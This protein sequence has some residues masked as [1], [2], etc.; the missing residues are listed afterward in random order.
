M[1]SLFVPRADP[2]C[3]SP[4]AEFLNSCLSALPCFVIQ[5]RSET[6]K[7]KQM[8]IDIERERERGRGMEREKD[9]SQE[10]DQGR[11]RYAWRCRF[12]DPHDQ[13]MLANALAA[14]S[15]TGNHLRC[16]HVKHRSTKT[17][18][19]PRLSKPVLFGDWVYTTPE[20]AHTA[21]RYATRRVAALTSEYT[22]IQAPYRRIQSGTRAR[23]QCTCMDV[24][25]GVEGGWSTTGR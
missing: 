25:E 8:N 7:E 22:S 2:P 3:G 5:I 1:A 15:E 14:S 16:P 9:T 10:C 13:E 19:A 4:S 18:Q 11:P 12:T 21:P 20:H 24:I 6:E 17:G 23:N